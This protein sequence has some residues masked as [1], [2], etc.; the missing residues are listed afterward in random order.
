MGMV[1]GTAAYM[2]PEQAR[3][4]PVDK[5]ADIWAFGVVLY[6][7]LTGAR[8]F[9][10][11]DVSLTLASVMKSD[12]DP[13][14]LPPD[15]PAAVRTVLRRCLEKD[16]SQRIRDIGD[17]RLAMAGA[18]ETP[19]ATQSETVAAP[20]LRLWQRPALALGVPLMAVL[21]T[22]LAVWGLTRPDVVPADVMRFVIPPPVGAPFDFGALYPDLAI[23]AD[24]THVVYQARAPG[25]EPRLHLRPIDQLSGVPLRGAEGA[26]APFFSPNGEWVGFVAGA[27]TSTLAS[28][29]H[30]RRQL[31]G[32]RPDHRRHGGRRTAPGARWRRRTGGAHE[33]RCRLG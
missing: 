32:G 1:I 15:V 31:G 20:A 23:S 4:K 28:D 3:G 18:F 14:T 17:V 6:E 25:G 2:S 24:G 33:P 11:E 8:P 16:P 29:H 21:V 9:Q 19:G 30:C 12:V 13:R 10:G 5:R 26:V 7:M 22:G 27:Y